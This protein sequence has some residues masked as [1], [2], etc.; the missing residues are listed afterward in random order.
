MTKMSETTRSH[1][2]SVEAR[3]AQ[4]EAIERQTQEREFQDLWQW[5]RGMEYSI[6]EWEEP[7]ERSPRSIRE[8]RYPWNE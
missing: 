4:I 2:A 1:N 5:C 6:P 8:E 3:H 7:E